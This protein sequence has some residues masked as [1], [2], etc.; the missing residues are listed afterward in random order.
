[1]VQVF[2]SSDRGGKLAAEGPTYRTSQNGTLHFP[3]VD[4][5]D[6]GRY[7]CRVSNSS[8]LSSPPKVTIVTIGFDPSINRR[9]CPATEKRNMF[10][11]SRQLSTN[12]NDRYYR[13]RFID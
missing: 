2:W 13:Y 12:I 7:K 11:F 8:L 5:E 9:L 1:M 4:K 10:F 6:E 3:A